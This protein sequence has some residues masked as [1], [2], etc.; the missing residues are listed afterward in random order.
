MNKESEKERIRGREKIKKPMSKGNKAVLYTAICLAGILIAY[1][2]FSLTYHVVY[3][4]KLPST[5]NNDSGYVVAQGKGLYDKNGKALLLQGTNAGN[6]LIWEGWLGVTSIGHSGGDN[7]NISY[8]E[9]P[10]AFALDALNKNKNLTESDADIKAL[11]NMLSQNPQKYWWY[12]DN[13]SAQDLLLDWYYSNWWQEEDF[14]NIKNLGLNCIRLPFY[15]RTIMEGDDSNLTVKENAFK[16]IDWFV[17]NCAK[18]GLYC[19]LDCHGAVGSQNAYEHSGDNT[20]CTLWD[21]ETYI[22]ATITMWEAVA[23]HYYVEEKELGAWIAAYDLLNEPM[24]SYNHADL[25]GKKQ[26]DVFDRI[27]KAIREIDGEHCISVE[28]CW[29]HVNLPNPDSYGWTNVLYQQHWYNWIS[30]IVSFD[31][32]FFFKDYFLPFANYDCPLLIGEFNFFDEEENWKTGLEF[33]EKRGYSWTT[34]TYKAVVVGGWRTSWSLY[35]LQMNA[36]EQTDCKADLK[37]ASAEKLITYFGAL[38]TASPGYN[39]DW[40]TLKNIP[41]LGWTATESNTYEFLTNW[42]SGE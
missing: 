27:I 41:S 37:T 10:M 34:W 6:W 3:A 39:E 18:N 7:G 9:L 5:I 25:T 33:F 13:C 23:R 21:N 22:E 35:T 36:N 31:T 42:L 32:F 14:V 24:G 38:S 17:Q 1:T 12:E 4:V 2:L 8:D 11:R 20:Q 16:W 40:F 29:G 19:I 15:Y 28:G 30:N 26:W